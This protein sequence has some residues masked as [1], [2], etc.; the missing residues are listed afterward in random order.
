M[1]LWWPLLLSVMPRDVIYLLQENFYPTLSL[2]M[3]TSAVNMQLGKGTWQAR[4]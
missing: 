2:F 4:E 1:I 3:E